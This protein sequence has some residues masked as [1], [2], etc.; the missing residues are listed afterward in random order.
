MKIILT[1]KGDWKRGDRVFYGKPTD[2][3]FMIKLFR[4]CA[5]F[6]PKPNGAGDRLKYRVKKIAWAIRDVGFRARHWL[7][8][9]DMYSFKEAISRK[10][11]DGDDYEGEE[12]AATHKIVGTTLHDGRVSVWEWTDDNLDE[13]VPTESAEWNWTAKDRD[14]FLKRAGKSRTG[15]SG[16]RVFVTLDGKRV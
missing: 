13:G 3:I 4:F 15:C 2:T 6:I 14:A 1:L 7:R 12:R 10:F 5:I 16:V 9:R 11:F 8:F